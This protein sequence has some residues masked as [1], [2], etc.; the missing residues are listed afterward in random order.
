MP[1]ERRQSARRFNAGLII[2]FILLSLTLAGIVW[3]GAQTSSMAQ[4]AH[5]FTSANQD[6]PYRVQAIEAQTKKLNISADKLV[7]VVVIQGILREG[8][9]LIKED[10]CKIID[11][12]DKMKMKRIPDNG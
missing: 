6:L 5:K 8:Q 12:L 4:E 7:E 9:K 1:T 3:R 2:S 10:L 11:K